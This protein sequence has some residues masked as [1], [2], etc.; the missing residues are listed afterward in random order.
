MDF[1]N[2]FPDLVKRLPKADIP[3]DGLDSYLFQGQDQQFIFMH[4]NKDVDAPEHSHEAQWGIVIDGRMDITIGGVLRT[5]QKGD[6]YLI[7][8]DIKHSA[9]IYAGY[10]DL[11]L[12]NQKDRYKK[13]DGGG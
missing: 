1:E 12:F 8:K 10:T 4:F 2:V 13:K 7:P 6:T 3:I 5:L 9:K 11:T